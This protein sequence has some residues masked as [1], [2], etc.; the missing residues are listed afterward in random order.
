MRIND[1]LYIMIE[2]LLLT[3]II[4][5]IISIILGVRDKKD[6]LN[7]ILVNVF[8]NPIVTSIQILTYVLFG[9]YYMIVALVILE[10]LV[11]IT[12]GYIYLKVLKF[13]RIN[14]FILSLILNIASY[15]IG[16]FI[17]NYI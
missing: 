15:F 5:L 16:G 3:V 7:V 13:K 6:M 1:M 11:F 4:E 8:T 9:Y 10:I 12:E 14:P 2:C 17:S